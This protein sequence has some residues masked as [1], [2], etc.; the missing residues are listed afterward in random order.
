MAGKGEARYRITLDIGQFESALDKV[1][2][3]FEDFGSTL[4]KAFGVGG[5]FA[6]G[7]KA[8]EALADSIKAVPAALMGAVEHLV[9]YAHQVEIASAKTGLSVKAVQE[10]SIAARVTGGSL[11]DITKVIGKMEKNIGENKSAFDQMGLSLQKLK[12][13]SPDEAFKTV[14]NRLHEIKNPMELAAAG[15]AVFGKSWQD[16]AVIVKD[17]SVLDIAAKLGRTLGQEDVAAAAELG[18]AGRMLAVAWDAVQT[19]FAAGIVK[20]GALHA[21]M[22]GL[23]G[24]VASLAEWMKTNRDVIRSWADQGA[25]YA[26]NALV[27]LVDVVETGL[28][29]FKVLADIWTGLVATGTALAAT[30][31]LQWEVQAG[32]A[33]GNVGRIKAAWTEYK[34][35]LDTALTGAARDL[36]KHDKA[37]TGVV[38][39]AEKAR[40]VLS[41]LAKDVASH[42]GNL[43]GGDGAGG[44]GGGGFDVE[45]DAASAKK[46]MEKFALE[47]DARM[48]EAGQKAT[49]GLTKAFAGANKAIADDFIKLGEAIKKHLDP[50][51]AEA[52]T[53]KIL[54]LGEALRKEVL[55]AE[56]LKLVGKSFED[57][58]QEVNDLLEVFA[59][60]GVTAGQLSDDSLKKLEG[61]LN[62]V[63]AEVGLSEEGLLALG[64][65]QDEMD[66]REIRAVETKDAVRKRVH[67][68]HM[69]LLAAEAT[70][71]QQDAA[72]IAKHA[73]VYLEIGTAIGTVAAQ[74]QGPLGSA[75]R[76]VG[77]V[78]DGLGAHTKQAADNAALYAN[79]LRQDGKA[80]AD[81]ALKEAEFA[82]KVQATAA[83]VSTAIGIFKQYQYARSGA[84]AA[85]GGAAQGAQTGAQIGG[86]YGAVIGAVVGGLIGF[87]SGSEFRRVA[88][89]A[90]RV[91]GGRVSD[92]LAKAV[93][94]TMSE[95]HVSMDTASLLHISEFMQETGK[96][97]SEMGPQI[98]QLMRS[99]V[100][101][102]VP[103]AAGLK[104]L[105]SL[106]GQLATAAA[107][108][109][110]AA[111][112]ITADL[113]QQGMAAGKLTASM[114]AYIQTAF[115]EMA[116]GAKNILAGIALIGSKVPL[117]DMGTA[118]AQMFVA[119]F[120]A[121]IGQKGLVQAIE[122]N[123]KGIE[124]LYKKLE[125]EG[126]TAGAALLA[127]WVHLSSVI[128]GTSTDVKGF[129][130]TLQGM[131]QV[132]S[133]LDKMG[134][135]TKGA[136]D[137]LETGIQGTINSLSEAGVVGPEALQAIAPELAQIIA[138]HEKYGFAIDANTQK[139]IDQAKDAGI[140]F[141]TDPMQKVVDILT[142]IAKALGALPKT[143]DITTHYHSTGTPPG[144]GTFGFNDDGTPDND[145]DKSNSYALGGYIPATPGGRM[146]RVAEG[147]EGEYVVPESKMPGSGSG[148]FGGPA[149]ISIPVSIG[150]QQLDEIIMRRVRGGYIRVH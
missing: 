11:D 49:G 127:P 120:E 21:L 3:Q 90:G 23:V 70:A 8:A 14:V 76:G 107:A 75:L 92:N 43:L 83:A 114:Q 106:F 94:K 13:S 56:R 74:L 80:A 97:A 39:M 103:A 12:A 60:T 135:A 26:A 113:I 27:A 78:L 99:I 147:G 51:I 142:L 69:V 35:T 93:M 117:G 123:G 10:L 41:K 102:S 131:S 44:G 59:A 88:D 28:A 130:T 32:I 109:D 145:G 71:I 6:L 40:D 110:V 1:G 73:K 96:S 124:E 36:E 121:E 148:G 57:L 55:E 87:F 64:A 79:V 19:Q 72:L 30:F 146:I 116:T 149:V 137:A 85:A 54:L 133:G 2:K 66:T 63:N 67:A 82:Q 128:N 104:E 16:M 126:N 53:Q 112:K 81:A 98:E 68:N 7:E 77:G 58:R 50:K 139:L 9:E 42:A 45:K 4:A 33:T 89:E 100:D 17:P 15:T 115:T 108:G 138:A 134:F 125:D 86:A 47:L 118:A 24:V 84:A 111:Q 136:F 52:V 29:V 20:S 144:G 48:A 62:R 140:A 95:L 31:K 38:G 143:I 129:L 91:L 150:G 122:D 25:V 18:K 132:F 5:A 34:T 141:P 37:L 61:Q 101:G 46:E 22:N 105:D 119:G 65:V